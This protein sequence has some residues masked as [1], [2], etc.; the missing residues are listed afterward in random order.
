MATIPVLDGPASVA[1][2]P[3]GGRVW[4]GGSNGMVAV[5]DVAS[6]T[7]LTSFSIGAPSPTY[8]VDGLAIAPDGAKV[9]ALWGSLVVIDATTNLVVNSIYA[10]NNPTGMAL[11]AD[12]ARLV[13]GAQFGYGSFGF[14]GTVAIVDTASESVASVVNVWGLPMSIAITPDGSRAYVATPYSWSDTGYG[15]GYLN[16]PWVTGIDLVTST[17][18][19]GFSVGSP[20][21]GLVVTPDGARVY[22][23]VPGA[24][25]VKV[26]ST[27]TNSVVATI[28]TSSFPNGV[29]ILP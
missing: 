13:V 16:S 20:A 6:R 1:V 29:A 28:P 24:G 15:A 4:V 19:T 10:G 8:S 25:G 26:A 9:Y 3:D 18:S 11:S 22:V 5:V 12:G 2:A 17:L 23:A 27:T 7:M 21:R 14:Y